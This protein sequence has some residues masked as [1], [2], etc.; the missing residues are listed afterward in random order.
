MSRIDPSDD[1]PRR[2]QAFG[3]HIDSDLVLPELPGEPSPRRA[4]A[5]VRIRRGEVE[6]ILEADEPAAFRFADDQALLSWRDV[7]DFRVRDGAVIDYAPREGVDPALTSLPL[8]GPVMGVLLQSRGLLT[9]HGSAIA[10]DNGVAIFLGDKGAGKSTTAATLVQAGKAL[11][12]DDIV[13]IE[14][15]PPPRLHPAYPQVKLTREAETAIAVAAQPMARPHPD[16]EKTRLL[17]EAPFDPAPR[18]PAVAFVLQRGSAFAL[19]P[20]AGADALMALMRFSYATRFGRALI[21]GRTAAAH[22]RQ[23]ADLARRIP[24]QRLTVPNGLERLQGLPVWLE[25]RLADLAAEPAR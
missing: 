9:L 2:Y 7:G 23:C 4:A 17:I 25:G 3:L 1:C 13:A 18:P 8:L 10:L 15:G 6:C 22:L 21:H 5:D 20:L 24:V 14:G 11:L 19:A 16:F 12:T